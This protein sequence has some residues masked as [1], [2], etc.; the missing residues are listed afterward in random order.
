MRSVIQRVLS[1]SVRVDGE[2]VGAID[3]PGLLVYL[4]VTHT[5][6]DAD[7]AWTARKIW[8][9]RLLRE[10]RSASDVDAP[11]LVVSQFTLYG[12]ARKGRRPTWQAAAPGPVSEPAYEAVC[13]ELERL[14]AT[15]ERG[16]FGADMQVTSVN[17]GP[18]TLVLDS[19]ATP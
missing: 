3:R 2:T 6:G 9:L 12:D 5:D 17:D 11:V 14:G 10:E 15:V 16:R 7:V 18:V 13:A 1:A 19:P 4:G 8:D